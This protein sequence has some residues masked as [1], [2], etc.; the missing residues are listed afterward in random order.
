MTSIVGSSASTEKKLFNLND[1]ICPLVDDGAPYSEIGLLE[2]SV[3]S[4]NLGIKQPLE[5]LTISD[6]LHGHKHW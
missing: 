2:R 1:Q 6:N 3:L 4:E 5:L